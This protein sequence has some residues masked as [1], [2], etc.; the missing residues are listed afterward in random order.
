MLITSVILV[1]REVLEAA[2]LISVLLALAKHLRLGRNWLGWA[3]PLAVAGMILYAGNLARITDA[4]DG[5]GQEVSNATMQLLVYALILLTVSLSASGAVS[6]ARRRKV[7]AAAMAVTVALAMVREGAE[8]W[9]YVS[10]FSMSGGYPVAVYAGSI[11]GAGIGTSVGILL[12]ALLR[13]QTPARR[14]GLC[15][16]LLCLT[17]AGMVMQ[18]TMP[19]QQVDYLPTGSALWDTSWLVN[20]RSIPGELLY[21]VFGYEATPSLLQ[22]GLY[23]GCLLLLATAAVRGL[24]HQEQ[25]L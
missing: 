4:L 19:L 18:A 10:G 24:R 14:L 5:A 15:L 12:F 11:I 21:A 6:S 13:V 3:I 2:V 22:V 1:L 9:V 20:E 17:G 23:I 25:Q 7:L 16:A 8:I